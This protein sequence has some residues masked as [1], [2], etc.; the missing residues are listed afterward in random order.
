MAG[1]HI[2]PCSYQDL[3]GVGISFS[4]AS[5][6]KDSM[7]LCAMAAPRELLAVKYV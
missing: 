5:I 6:H 2:G 7:T 1:I 4:Q 3:D